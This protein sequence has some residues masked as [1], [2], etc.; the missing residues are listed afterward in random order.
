MAAGTLTVDTPAPAGAASVRFDCIEGLRALAA[1]AVFF[2]HV[3][4]TRY[5]QGFGYHAVGVDRYVRAWFDQLQVGVPI[6]FAISGFVMYR[7]FVARH[8]GGAPEPSTSSY[9]ARRV[10]RIYP[11]YWVALIATVL[12]VSDQITLR[13]PGHWAA[14]LG[15]VQW[16]VPGGT[17]HGIVFEGMIQAWTLTAEVT[18]YA[19]LPLF[20]LAMR[21]AS[22]R[23]PLRAHRIGVAAVVV[24]GVA[25]RLWLVYGAPPTWVTV[26]PVYLAF[27]GTGMAIAIVSVTIAGGGAAPGRS[28]GVPTTRVGAPARPYWPSSPTPCWPISPTAPSSGSMPFRRGKGSRISRCSGSSSPRCCSPPCS[29][30]RSAGECGR[31]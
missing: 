17:G 13:G 23:E 16:Y 30:S 8:V 5:G 12:V 25:A 28:R 29:A 4:E 22:R 3:S 7:P 20:A 15:L 2:I 27:F 26:L 1:L 18:F 24:A 21:R 31:R 19:A 6:F 11:A 9:V 14:N 10:L